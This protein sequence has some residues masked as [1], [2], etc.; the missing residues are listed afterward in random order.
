M[1]TLVPIDKKVLPY[2]IRRGIRRSAL[3]VVSYRPNRSNTG[4]AR[5]IP[6][7]GCALGDPVR[8]LPCYP[9]DTMTICWCASD[10]SHTWPCPC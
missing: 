7:R 10:P 5:V 4:P 9:G 8:S 1:L 6:Q 3:S 2:T